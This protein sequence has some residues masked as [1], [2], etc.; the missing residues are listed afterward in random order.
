MTVA[1]ALQRLVFCLAIASALLASGGAILAATAPTETAAPAPGE[2]VGQKL[3]L[4]APVGTD[5]L[6]VAA[7]VARH[8][9]VVE[10][11]LPRLGL[12]LVDF[13]AV[14][15]V[16]AALATLAAEPLVDFV[17]E[18]RLIV[19]AAEIPLDPYWPQQWGP[20]R[21]QGPAA[22]DLAWGDP[23]VVIAVVDS[24]VHQGH[25]DL[26]ANTWYN[27]GESGIDP[28]TGRR[29][30]AA[31][32]AVNGLDDD[33]NGYV[34]DCRGYDFV[35]RDVNSMDVLGHGTVVAG[36]AAAA[37]NN[38]DPTAPDFYEGIAGM[39]RQAGLMAVRVLNARGSGSAF[40]VAAGID[41]ATANGARVIN[42]S[43]TFPPSYGPDSPDVA[44]VRRAVEAAQAADVLVVAASGN[45][46][47]P[48]VDCPACFAGVLAVG[49][50]T[51]TD[52]RAWFSNH[53]NR[54]D[55][56]APGVGIFSTLLNPGNS[57][58]GLYNNSGSGTSFAA[59]HAAG[60]AA[61]VRALRPDLHQGDVHALLR[62]TADDVG[63]P[64]FDIWTG[65]GRLN[66]QRAVTEA[67]LGLRLELTAG[68]TSLRVGDSTDLHLRI[69]A[70]D[71]S[72]AGLGGRVALTANLG[73]VTPTM[74]TLDGTG[75]AVAQFDAS[76]RPGVVYVQTV[77]G[78]V[79]VSIPLTIGSGLP[80]TMTLAAMPTTLLSGETAAVVATVLDEG[81]NP[82]VDGLEVTFAAT[83]GSVAPITATTV[84]GQA[85][86]VFTAGTVGGTAIVTAEIMDVVAA[87]PLRVI[88]AGDPWMLELIA[89]PT[90]I[91][92]GGAPTVITATVRDL[93]GDL[94]PDGVMVQFVTDLGVL[95]AAEIA[96]AGGQA[97]TQLWPG[98]TLG[99]ARVQATAGNAQGETAVAI[100]PG[101][102]SALVLSAV[103]SR[104]GPGRGVT[105]RARALDLYGN[106]ASGSILVTF[107]TDAGTVDPVEVATAGSTAVTHL[108]LPDQP[109]L[110]QVW[111]HSG[112]LSAMTTVEVVRL[113]YHYLPVVLR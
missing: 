102:A 35:D 77:L 63:L 105:V 80:A 66:A 56:V 53:A 103:P 62:M 104:A 68:A 21:V 81:G 50:S 109:G 42:L 29:T 19:R 59:P 1:G 70:P 8:G 107:S 94:V 85:S 39:A 4:A 14:P 13:P 78:P 32:P 73:T 37:T 67:V 75:R 27:P 83:L 89:H 61:L 25:Y 58:Y 69:L 38:P 7:L 96:T 41:Y 64:G 112:E 79:Q 31:W 93:F 86:T 97:V 20:A 28:V 3:V 18:H 113:A 12:A 24:G 33:G 54:L 82:V 91:G 111:A 88:G 2:A 11:W 72:P 92:L 100:E 108:T 55:L 52:E 6:Q 101:S 84:A 48:I 17:A 9:G 57:S 40:D 36:I 65:W 76:D 44:A 16:A 95:A 74:V 10:R 26:A 30:C 45:E 34:D 23:S 110:V 51:Q 106:P 49:A 47:Q 99:R 46:N 71:G 87:V 90:S 60:V 98:D 5:V 43:L 15:P 22:W